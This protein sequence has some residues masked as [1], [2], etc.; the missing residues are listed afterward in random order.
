MNSLKSW[1]L[2]LLL[3]GFSASGCGGAADPDPIATDD[4]GIVDPSDAAQTVPG[5]DASVAA[6]DA[7]GAGADA[8]PIDKAAQCASTF[9]S[10]LTNAYGR[11]D[12][13]V[14]AVVKPTDTQCP[15]PNGDHLVIQV[16]VGGEAYRMVVNVQSDGRNGTD[17]RMKLAEVPHALMGEA[18]SEGWHPGA[19]LD[20]PGDLGA[21]VDAFT[22]YVMGEL[23]ERVAA[24]IDLGARISFFASSRNAPSSAHLIHRNDG[25]AAA[26]DGAIVIGPDSAAPLYLLFAF[27]GT[28]F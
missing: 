24:R 27:D 14:L 19:S 3:A 28:T 6:P 7:G 22:P 23:V 12:G 2:V 1:S 8:G 13:T 17:T 26:D 18:W 11:L 5:A 4:A 20:Y 16:L 9:G 21:H 15:I 10:G 25:T